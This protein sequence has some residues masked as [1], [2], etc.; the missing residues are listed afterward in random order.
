MILFRVETPSQ[1][2]N[3]MTM[4]YY[5]PDETADIALSAAS[6]FSPFVEGLQQTKLF[7][8]IY[9]SEDNP[10]QNL[11]IVERLK[12]DPKLV[13]ES[14]ELLSRCGYEDK[15]YTDLYVFALAMVYNHLLYYHMVAKHG[16]LRIHLVEEGTSSYTLSLQEIADWAEMEMQY[17]KYFPQKTWLENN[18]TSVWLYQPELNV[19]FAEDKVQKI[20]AMDDPKL[21]K[22][23]QKVFGTP[24]LPKQKYI[25]FAEPTIEECVNSCSIEIL[26]TIAERVGK[27]NMIVKPHPRMDS[28]LFSAAGYSVQG[29]KQLPWEI[30]AFDAAVQEKI[31]LTMSSSSIFTSK[32]RNEHLRINAIYLQYLEPFPGR[33]HTIQKNYEKFMKLVDGVFNAEERNLFL[34][35]S[36]DQLIMALDYFDGRMEYDK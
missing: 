25:F 29:E 32:L 3:A 24:S 16:A 10:V 1:L 17:R 5:L 15:A 2:I 7:E 12:A 27:E 20:P 34:P 22:M 19:A 23:L 11:E 36:H 4:K 14:G 33:F 13:K 35:R 31:L 30:Y 6:D 26:N 18:L 28:F 9:L 8:N 21:L